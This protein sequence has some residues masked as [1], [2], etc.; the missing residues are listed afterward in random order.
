MADPIQAAV[1]S[2]DYR[3]AAVLCEER[4]MLARA[5]DLYTR[6][7]D[8]AAAGRLAEAQGDH[9]GAIDLFL[10]GNHL[11]QA[12]SVRRRLMA[13]L[14]DDIP[15]ALKLFEQRS[16]F[17]QAAELAES[18]GNLA[19]GAR[20]YVEAGSYGRAGKLFER[21]GSFRKAGE[22]YEAFLRGRLDDPT[23]NLGLGRVL[24][25][26]GR[27]REAI[28]LLSRALSDVKTADEAT[29]RIGYSFFKLDLLEAGRHALAKLGLSRTIDPDDFM[30]PFEEELLHAGAD[31]AGSAGADLQGRYRVER[32]LPERLGVAY[33][34]RDLL[35]DQPVVL[36]FLPGTAEDNT[37]FYEEIGRL[38]TP[39][40]SGAVR[41]LEIN[42]EAGFVATEHVD[43]A[44]LLDLLESPSPPTALRCRSFAVQ[45]LETLREAH[46]RGTLHGSLTARALLIAVGDVCRVDD[47]GMHHIE[48]RMATQTGG[49]ES[50]FAYRAPELNIGRQ[51]DFSA[52]LYALAAVLYR[53]LVGQPP[54]MGRA[55]DGLADWPA[56]FAAFFA[57]A[58]APEPQGRH[59]NHEQFRRELLALPWPQVG[60]RQVARRVE[61]APIAAPSGGPRFVVRGEVEAFRP[62][63]AHDTLLGRDVRLLPLG[64]DGALPTQLVARLDTLASPERPAFQDVSRYDEH[65]HAVVLEAITAVRFEEF[66]AER[67]ALD[68]PTLLDAA[69]A[70]LFA[71]AATHAS[72]LGLG[73][74]SASEVRY[75]GLGFRVL[76]EDALAVDADFDRAAIVTD[77]R[78]FW[79][80]IYLG[81]AGR[82]TPAPSPQRLLAFLRAQGHLAAR[83][84]AHLEAAIPA[85]ID[86]LSGMDAWFGE[87]VRTLEGHQSRKAVFR[88][89]QGLAMADHVMND[90]ERAYL[91]ERRAALGLDD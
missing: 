59:R 79:D 48:R 83:D 27:H 49:P 25:R 73:A 66:V 80:L 51:G 45:A 61:A 5:Q 85:N 37:D 31:E 60:Q 38:R 6:L 90:A 70:L 91:E 15:A 23:S 11:E 30:R 29:R 63:S 4:G 69:E 56:A 50:A 62:V 57:R 88:R 54:A 42:P 81:A 13:E 75:D 20:L 14:S 9:I 77:T 8:Y 36:R 39:P 53:A 78:G 33:L 86:S 40:I 47:W 34:G 68:L 41:I 74:I 52:D 16:Y 35:R 72:G 46:Q 1:D 65:Q 2:G 21:V 12:E 7:F 3:H 17:L 32:P 43:G 28:P 64:D 26:F 44:T 71:L 58:L 55:A 76:I 24:Q 67:G 10:R 19:Q 84:F 82:A 18:I 22:A 87:L 89:L